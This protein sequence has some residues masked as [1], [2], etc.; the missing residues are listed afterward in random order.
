M[1]SKLPQNHD[2]SMTWDDDLQQLFNHLALVYRYRI[3]IQEKDGDFVIKQA[4]RFVQLLIAN[5]A[6]NELQ[7]SQMR[8]LCAR[9][10]LDVV[11]DLEIQEMEKR[12]VQIQHQ[13]EEEQRY[14]EELFAV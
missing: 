12:L 9:L 11:V 10:N 7:I 4:R 2:K 6:L 1:I 3:E 14:L 5:Y 8:Q 13:K